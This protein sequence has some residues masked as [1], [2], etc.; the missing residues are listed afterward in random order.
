MEDIR[1]KILVCSDSPAIDTGMGIAHRA[2]A[3]KLHESGRF[4][5]VS[6]GWFWDSAV[7]RDIKWNFPW[8]Q[9]STSDRQRPYG[10]PKNW[11][12]HESYDKVKVNDDFSDSPVNKVIVEFQPNIVIAIGDIWMLD[13]LY[14][15]PTRH[16]FK[17]IHEFPIDGEPIPQ[18]WVRLI[19]K[20]D[21]AVVMS[22]YAMKICKAIDPYVSLER[23]PRGIDTRIF[24][25]LNVDKNKL[26][27]QYL[28]STQNRFVVGVFDRFQ[29]RKQVP[30]A[31]EGFAKFNNL[32]KVDDSDIYLHLDV[33]DS[34]SMQQKKTLLGEN[35]IIQRYD[36]TKNVIVDTKLTV[37]KG[38]SEQELVALYNCVDVKLS[39][40]QGEGFGL[41]V[42]GNTKILTD[43]G[44]QDIKDI[45]IG[46][47]VMS[48]DGCFHKIIGKTH[49]TVD[50]INDI[51]ISGCETVSVT[52]EHPFLASK[53]CR[54][55]KYRKLEWLNVNE[56]CVGDFIAIPKQLFPNKT[57]T[58]DL[59]DLDSNIYYNESHVWYNTGYSG[60]N[61]NL[62]ISNIRNMFGVGSKCAS[63]AILI[64]T[65]RCN[66]RF[67]QYCKSFEI[68]QKI[69]DEY[70]NRVPNKFSR[71]VNIDSDFL[72]CLGWYLAE[73]S[74]YKNNI[75]FYCGVQDKPYMKRC[76][77]WF[78]RQG[79][80][81]TEKEYD[82][83]YNVSISSTIHAR[84]F[85][86][87][88]GRLSHAKRIHK[89]LALSDI[90]L[91]PLIEAYMLG[92]GHIGKNTFSITTKSPHLAYQIRSILSGY[93][94]FASIRYDNVRDF[95]YSVHVVGKYARKL[96]NHIKIKIKFTDRLGSAAM[97]FGDFFLLPIKRMKKRTGSFDVYD[98]SVQDVHSFVGNGVLLHNTT[99][100]ALSCGVPCIATNCTTMPEFLSGGRGLLADVSTYI[101]GQ[102]N[103]E[104][105]LVD[106]DSVAKCLELLYRS[107]EMRKHMGAISR[108]FAL[109]YD[110]GN[111]FPMWL[112]I[113][114]KLLERPRYE[115]YKQPTSVTIERDKQEINV[116]G[117]LY[118][119]TGFSVATS[120]IARGLISYGHDVSID[121]REKEPREGCTINRDLDK[122]ALKQKYNDIDII[123]H[124]PDTCLEHLK[125]SKAR[126]K[127]AYFPWE[128]TEVKDEWIDLINRECDA[129]WCNS[130]FVRNIFIANGAIKDKIAVIPNGV[131][132]NTSAE[133]EV[134]DTKKRYKFLMLGNLGD[135]RKNVKTL[136]QAY[137]NTFTNKDDVCLVLKSQPGHYDSDPT[138]LCELLCKGRENM[139]E[140]EIIHRDMNDLSGL[141][142]ACDCFVT[143]THAEGFCQPI[144]DALSVGMPVIAPA[145]GGYGGFVANAHDI[146]FAL[147]G[148]MADA[149]K[150]NA[151]IPNSL[152]FNVDYNELTSKMR[153]VYDNNV[154]RNGKNYVPEYTWEKAGE[155]M[156]NELKKLHNRPAKK[157]VFYKNFSYNMWNDD[158][159]T[160]IMRYAPD[161]IQF[162]DDYR[163][164]GIQ[165]LDIAKLADFNN[166]KCDKYI[167]NFHCRG[168]ASE[169]DIK[170]YLPYFKKAIAAYSHLDLRSELPELTNFIR[171]P[172]GT[173]QR[174][175]YEV[176]ADRH[177]YIIMN[178][179]S[180]P[181]TE[182][183]YES[184]LAAKA[185]GL[186]QF[187]TGPNLGIKTD[188]Y[189]VSKNFLNASQMRTAYSMCAYTSGMRRIE[190]FEKTVAEGL[191]CGSR[192]ICFDTPLYRYWY[193]DLVEYV[194]EG[195]KEETTLDLIK[196]FKSDYRFVTE[197]EK[198]LVKQTFA[199]MHVAPLYWKNIAKLGGI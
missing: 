173:N 144:L 154:T 149:G 99:L 95:T 140:L 2:I 1:P 159:R 108:Q 132:I 112:D 86:Y 65:N 117:A 40:T 6:F 96:S 111:V 14:F 5:V 3:R 64:A 175:F 182:G 68:A 42:L 29:D 170:D 31:I 166:L 83:H 188:S 151:Y 93:D 104:R 120:G 58:K 139:P 193:G 155:L 19:K 85:E 26:R 161:N 55:S 191:M 196:I 35:G 12:F 165:I 52:D 129:Y 57:A 125:N 34:H 116:V 61:Q 138:E 60:K 121:A 172:W 38:V 16:T 168:F 153:H 75:S 79:C 23:I 124:M 114:D 28:P 15:L 137:L 98:I 18:S 41:C 118:E 169:E 163:D 62:S 105:A 171:G 190:G 33:N 59:L 77:D 179:G 20:A 81:V 189:N 148:S 178:T 127:I 63:R 9:Y 21:V 74:T 88:G 25:P 147:K 4:F 167:I 67:T 150:C 39:T 82:K 69:K 192:P 142:K 131:S 30:R 89:D 134:M 97:E 8:K 11:D 53:D 133:P 36:I 123:N 78:V 50:I 43:F 162:V 101:T 152:W 51:K 22:K 143:A 70:V 197:K 174:K 198:A 72:Y 181:E 199:W 145:Y 176:R 185:L 195:T 100:E 47:T 126:I 76:I 130:N 27:E 73:G 180:I 183:V 177:A 157:R 71:Y 184:V 156:T 110:W 92:D 91:F 119:N 44:I 106:T 7:S 24:R 13:Y 160:N 141:F 146:F 84:L 107:V 128:L 48:E 37:E 10:H 187:H 113:V 32:H 54:R 158:N 194:R 122:Y 109:Q 103:V 186:K 136:I 115:L 87:Y 90:N 56:L 135:P 17:L 49:R 80:N 102:Y 66:E 45:N 94:I 46:T 164:A